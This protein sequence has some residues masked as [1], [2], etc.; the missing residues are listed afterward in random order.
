VEETNLAED[1]ADLSKKMRHMRTPEVSLLDLDDITAQVF[2][3]KP[4]GCK[5]K[6]AQQ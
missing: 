4:E 1:L 2:T 3:A 6:R 5:S